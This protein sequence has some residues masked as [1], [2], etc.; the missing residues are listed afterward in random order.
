MRYHWIRD[1]VEEIFSI[2]W[3]PGK[4]NTA[5]SPTKH[6]IPIYHQRIISVY[7]DNSTEEILNNIHSFLKQYIS[8]P[9]LSV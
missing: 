9:S 3:E 1:K 8:R 4:Y 7:M 2:N 5:D 6:W